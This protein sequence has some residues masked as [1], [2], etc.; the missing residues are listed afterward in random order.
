MPSLENSEAAAPAAT[1]VEKPV[2]H[3]D[4]SS[5]EREGLWQREA[6]CRLVEILGPETSPMSALVK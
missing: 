4:L 6:I 2:H 5:F 3:H 1:A